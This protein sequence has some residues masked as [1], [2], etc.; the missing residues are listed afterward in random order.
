M[1]SLGWLTPSSICGNRQ[2]AGRQSFARATEWVVSNLMVKPPAA[3]PEMADRAVRRL[4]GVVIARHSPWNT[5]PRTKLREAEQ[6]TPGF[7]SPTVSGLEDSAWCAVR[8][9]VKRSEVIPIMERLEALGAS[10]IL[11]TQI[12]NCRL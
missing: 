3:T 10:A 1:I 2:H 8:V 11:E 5:T 4:E 9:M 6:I 12:T 7:K